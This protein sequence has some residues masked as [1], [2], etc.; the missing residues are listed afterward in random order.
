DMDGACDQWEV[1][2]CQDDSACNYDSTATDSGYCAYADAGYDCTGECLNDADGDGVCDENEI[3]GCT[4]SFAINYQPL[5]TDSTD[6][7]L[8]PS[9]FEPDCLYDFSQDGYVG[10]ADLLLFLAN[11]GSVCE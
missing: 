10:T 11:L 7:C 6:T 3:A 9:D 2:G 1:T 8:Y 4:D 5:A